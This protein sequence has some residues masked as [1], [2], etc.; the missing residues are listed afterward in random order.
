M[1][2]GTKANRRDILTVF[3]MCV[4][5]YSSFEEV[6]KSVIQW[7][8]GCVS[9]IVDFGCQSLSSWTYIREENRENYPK[10]TVVIG[11]KIQL[12]CFDSQKYQMIP[13][14][15]CEYYVRRLTWQ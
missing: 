7:V 10:C 6:G 12:V 14:E 1:S 11:F 13:L 4:S 15:F 5:W 3:A 8:K 2:E 9:F